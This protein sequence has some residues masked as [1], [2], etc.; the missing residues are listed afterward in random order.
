VSFADRVEQTPTAEAKVALAAVG[1]SSVDL[2]EREVTPLLE[3]RD[4]LPPVIA[5]PHALREVVT[6]FAAGTGPVAIDAERASGYRYGHRAYLVQ[7]RR[8][9]VGTALIDPIACPDLAE[10]GAAIAGDEWVLHAAS[11]DLPSLAEVGLVPQRIFDTELAGRLLCL[12]RV[13]LG[14]MVESVLGH[15]LEK[16]HSAVDWSVRPLPEPWLRYAALDVELLIEL[17]DALDERLTAAGKRT[18]AAEEF[19]AIV[20]SPK[21]TP[22]AEPWRRTSGIHR[23]RGRRQ[24]A[25]VRALWEARDRLA[26]ARDVAPGRVVPDSAIIAAALAGVADPS[27]LVKRPGFGGRSTSRHV[28]TFAAALRDSSTLPDSELPTPVP[29]LD[30]PPP[31]Q[32]W[33]ERDPLAAA[34]LLRAREAVRALAAQLDVPTE[35]LLA[36]DAVRRLAWAPPEPLTAE[37]VDAALRG[38]RARDWQREHTVHALVDALHD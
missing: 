9:G 5:E 16:G 15:A 31:A 37:A 30:G 18:W 1:Q 6:A 34:R 33:P 23:V 8:T 7:L 3:P 14:P 10:L 17:R 24:L 11:Q 26:R 36:P 12:P 28:Q 2:Q 13:G 4:G 25:A 38:L 22:R 21:A 32:R 27:E 19:A 35:N 29:P 20:N